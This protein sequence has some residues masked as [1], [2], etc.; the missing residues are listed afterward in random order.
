MELTGSVASVNEKAV[1]IQLD[2]PTGCGA[3]LHQ[4][5][6]A[7]QGASWLN[8]WLPSRFSKITLPKSGLISAGERVRVEIP[9]Q[10]GLS[11]AF[12]GYALPIL[13]LLLGSF[14]GAFFQPLSL[15]PDNAAIV[16]G[17]FGFIGGLIAYKPLS[18]RILKQ[19][20]GVSGGL[21]VRVFPLLSVE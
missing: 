12:V 10:L 21:P 14:L 4:Q 6:C 7:D 11:L 3:C 13:L 17:C 20:N 8:A 2:A 18:G 9:D 19:S 16:G 5:A 15:L 1:I